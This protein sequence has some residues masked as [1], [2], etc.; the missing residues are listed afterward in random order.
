[1]MFLTCTLKFFWVFFL[2]T[3][4]RQ[5]EVGKYYFWF[6]NILHIDWPQCVVVVNILLITTYTSIVNN[7]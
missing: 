5:A 2:V 3:K 4:Y 1:M 6:L 7:N